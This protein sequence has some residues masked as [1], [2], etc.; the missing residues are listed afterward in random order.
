MAALPWV[1]LPAAAFI[2]TVADGHGALWLR[3]EDAATVLLWYGL[4][5]GLPLLLLSVCL[6]C[7]LHKEA[8]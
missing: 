8:A 5:Y 4:L 2:A 6:A 7:L 3:R 1:W